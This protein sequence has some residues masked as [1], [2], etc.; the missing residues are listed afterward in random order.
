MYK[1]QLESIFIQCLLG[2]FPKEISLIDFICVSKR[3]YQSVINYKL[4]YRWFNQLSEKQKL[5][6]SG[7]KEKVID[8]SKLNENDIKYSTLILNCEDSSKKI[9]EPFASHVSEIYITSISQINFN[10][11]PLLSKVNILLS[12]SIPK[13]LKNVSLPKHILFVIHAKKFKPIYELVKSNPQT[14]FIGYVFEISQNDITLMNEL[15]NIKI[16]FQH[17]E[18]LFPWPSLDVSRFIYTGIKFYLEDNIP[19]SFTKFIIKRG[20][21]ETFIRRKGGSSKVFLDL[22]RSLLEGINIDNVGS[23]LMV[24]VPKSLEIISSESLVN[25]DIQGMRL[26]THMTSLNLTHLKTT[27][28]PTSIQSLELRINTNIEE[29]NLREFRQLK[30]VTLDSYKKLVILKL[31]QLTLHSLNLTNCQRLKSIDGNKICS[32]SVC[33]CQQLKEFKVSYSKLL[34]SSFSKPIKFII[35]TQVQ[36]LILENV[37]ELFSRQ[38]PFKVQRIELKSEPSEELICSLMKLEVN[39]LVLSNYHYG[40]EQLKVNQVISVSDGVD[41]FNFKYPSEVI[42]SPHHSI[43]LETISIGKESAV[44][45]LVINKAKVEELILTDSHVRCLRL[46]SSTIVHFIQ[47]PML[48]KIVK[49]NSTIVNGRSLEG[50]VQ[51]IYEDNDQKKEESSDSSSFYFMFFITK[52]VNNGEVNF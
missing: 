6:F 38:I 13:N 36:N 1:K 37:I 24:Y 51:E 16:L 35:S 7:I 12:Y 5:L 46:E 28:F 33:Q 44:Q 52:I 47:S 15:S 22:Q 21:I 31:P 43:E 50:I 41:N 40:L 19:E 9:R 26:C 18:S 34:L 2:Y 29:L 11:L 27:N 17:W 25:I 30:D 10:E 23:P 42:I 14:T 45:L 3:I 39:T 20:L 32:I 48:E 4:E 8:I 49:L